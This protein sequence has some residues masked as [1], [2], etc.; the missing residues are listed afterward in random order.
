M[1]EKPQDNLHFILHD[2]PEP[3][4]LLV[5]SK[6]TLGRFTILLP[7]T[8]VGFILVL[9]IFAW[10]KAPSLGRDLGQLNLPSMPV[11]SPEENR[12]KELEAEL[13]AMETTVAAITTKLNSGTGT[14]SEIWLGPIKRPYALQDLTEKKLLRMEEVT[15][16]SDAAHQVLRFNL[17]NS[18]PESQRALGHIFVLQLHD[19][20][21]NLY[22]TPKLDELAQGIRFD[23]GESFAV[24]R[25]RPVE[26]PFPPAKNAHF[27]V[28]IF[29]RDGD[30]LIR[31]DLRG[32][33]KSKGN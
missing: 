1:L 24:S 26:A 20:G 12:I 16:E 28:L 31:E 10:F 8:L 33:F 27:L 22:P 7:L 11:M 30:L 21:L 25:L 19:Q 9:V 15:L 23:Q 4:R 3:P 32:P 5:V 13:K 2:A 17:V 14:E 18:G 6:K 29:S